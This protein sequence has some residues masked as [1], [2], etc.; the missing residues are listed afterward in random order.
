M[1]SIGMKVF[2]KR[3]QEKFSRKTLTLR[4][5]VEDGTRKLASDRNAVFAVYT[6]T[7]GVMS[8][9]DNFGNWRDIHLSVNGK[10]RKIPV[11]KLYYKVL[12]NRD[13]SSGIALIGVNNP[14]LTLEEIKKDYIICTDVSEQI[15]YINWQKDDIRRGYSYA[16]DVNDFVKNVP[17]FSEIDVKS[18]LI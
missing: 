15:N 4:E 13:D 10:T 3:S 17:H 5:A 18:L 9:E 7:I 16:C 12:I 6:G 8:L 14:H 2:E 11:P 1:L